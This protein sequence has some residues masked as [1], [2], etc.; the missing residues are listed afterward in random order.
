MLLLTL[1]A[2]LSPKMY[3][4]VCT[5]YQLEVFLQLH[6]AYRFSFS[7]MFWIH[8]YPRIRSPREPYV[9]LVLLLPQT[10]RASDQLLRLRDSYIAWENRSRQRF[11]SFLPTSSYTCNQ[12]LHVYLVARW[13]CRSAQSCAHGTLADRVPGQVRSSSHNALMNVT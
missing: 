13:L 10:C 5:K 2:S 3:H 9:L 11:V 12:I 8:L 4:Y 7:H 1:T 6:A